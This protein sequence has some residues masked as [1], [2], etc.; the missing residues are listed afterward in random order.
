MGLRTDLENSVDEII[1]TQWARREGRVVP[2]SDDS[3][4]FIHDAVLLD[5]TFVYA[6]L[7]DSTALAKKDKHL[8]AEV[9]QAF[10]SCTS[11][12]LLSEGGAIRSFDGD[13]VMAVFIGD[14]RNSRAA[15]CALKIS[16][17]FS[18]IV[19]PKLE[20]AYRSKLA[21]YSLS[22]GSG[23]DSGSVWA[24]R[25]GVRDNS[26]LIWVGRAPNLAAKL[27]AIRDGVFYTFITGSVY[28]SLDKSTKF[29]PDG[30]NMWEERVWTSEDKMRIYRSHYR[31]S[32]T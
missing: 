11:R 24:V 25:G 32:V 22:Y 5:A 1:R 17:V 19:K 2:E 27:S 28:D 13:R 20:T 29:A 10:L 3:I 16:W 6:D 4:K 8:T 31:W 23:I 18:M 21:S 7:A 26:D 9:L 14:D 30:R 12:V 15:R